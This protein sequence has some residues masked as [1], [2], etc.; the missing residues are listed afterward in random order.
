[1]GN[2]DQVKNRGEAE[3]FYEVYISH[4]DQS[5]GQYPIYLTYMYIDPILAFYLLA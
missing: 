4:I 1:M 5:Q 2:I 3:V